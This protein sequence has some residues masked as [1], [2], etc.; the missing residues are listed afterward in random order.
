MAFSQGGAPANTHVE[1]MVH[2]TALQVGPVPID[3]AK[4]RLRQLREN[5]RR[6]RAEFNLNHA[7]AAHARKRMLPATLTKRVKEIACIIHDV[8][9]PSWNTAEE[10]LLRYMRK[11]GVQD[12]DC[13][14]EL[15]VELNSEYHG[16][17]EEELRRW[18][19]PRTPADQRKKQKRCAS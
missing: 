1:T 10:Y 18:R 6:A 12:A 14:D 5:L 4:S 19:T 13:I 16:A 11:R 9:Y 8:E 7:K 15:R 2:G 3:S 17:S